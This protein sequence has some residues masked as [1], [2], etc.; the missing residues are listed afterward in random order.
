VGDLNQYLFV[1]ANR[2]AF[3]GSYLEVGS[4]DV[5]TPGRIRGLFAGEEYVGL[6]MEPGE[7]VD[8]A[9][10]L[11]W[12]FERVDSALGGRRFGTVFCL[13][14]LEHCLTPHAM[15]VNITRLLAPNGRVFVSV[16]FA[17][18]VHAFPSDYWRFTPDG[19]RALFPDLVFDTGLDH[20]ATSIVGETFPLDADLG[21]LSVKSAGWHFKR[22]RR[23][24]GFEV[25]LLR[26]MSALGPLR[27]LTRY[28]YVIHPVMINMVGTLQGAPERPKAQEAL[29][30]DRTG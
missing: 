5:G 2:A 30:A 24:R 12:P 4:R 15:A 10:D 3:E 14:V 22:G 25:G 21:R 29:K 26:L 28:R 7:G 9:A 23:M 6:D 27:W 11:T 16:P 17:W 1:E 18:K 20:A 19:V 13:S 8:V